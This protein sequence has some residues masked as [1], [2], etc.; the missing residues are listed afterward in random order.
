MTVELA[1]GKVAVVRRIV[2]ETRRLL[3]CQG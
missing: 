2:A 1:S 3:A